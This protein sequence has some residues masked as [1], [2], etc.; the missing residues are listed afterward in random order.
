MNALMTPIT[1]IIVPKANKRKPEC[2]RNSYP[3]N[4]ITIGLSK[5]SNEENIT[6]RAVIIKY[7]TSFFQ[8]DI[9]VPNSYSP[10]IN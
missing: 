7:K 5:F 3:Q 2:I 6:E 4:E 9:C 10:S 1:N 8:N